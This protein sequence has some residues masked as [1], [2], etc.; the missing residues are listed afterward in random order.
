MKMAHSKGD[1]VSLFIRASGPKGES[2]HGFSWPRFGPV[3]E[4]SGHGLYGLEWGEGD[5][6]FLDAHYKEGGE[7]QVIEVPPQ[8]IVRYTQKA[9]F[10]GEGVVV[11]SS[12]DRDNALSYLNRRKA[13][14]IKVR[15]NEISGEREVGRWFRY[16]SA[17]IGRDWSFSLLASIGAVLGFWWALHVTSYMWG[18][19]PASEQYPILER[20]FFLV[21][22]T[23]CASMLLPLFHRAWVEAFG[24]PVID[25]RLALVIN[26]AIVRIVK[27][28]VEYFDPSDLFATPVPVEDRQRIV[29]AASRKDQNA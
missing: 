23:A 6:G 12:T 26:P 28:E 15:A 8:N 22:I 10:T 19:H 5:R 21:S 1:P 29:D 14:S 4:K 7:Y 18:F 3:S 24:M 9:K 27:S 11:Y 25:T 17:T 2:S 13:D 16:A 20:L